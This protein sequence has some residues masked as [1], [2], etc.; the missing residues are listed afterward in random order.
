[1]PAIKQVGFQQPPEA[2]KWTVSLLPDSTPD[3]K[4]L[5]FRVDGSVTGMCRT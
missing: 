4:R 2:Q 5:H 1:M 3:G